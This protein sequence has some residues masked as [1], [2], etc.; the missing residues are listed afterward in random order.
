MLNSEKVQSILDK[1]GGQFLLSNSADDLATGTTE[2]FYRLYFIEKSPEL[3]GGIVEEAKADLGSIGGGS[4]GQPVVSLTMNSE[5]SRTWSRVT[6]SNIGERI[7]IVL[8][9]KVHMAPSIREKIPGGRTQIEG[10]SDINEEKDIAI[11]L[12]AGA[13][14]AP[15]NI[16]EERLVGPSLG[17]DSIS[18]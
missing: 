3:T 5:G 1:S 14:P 2:E 13:L 17:A 15:V 18:Q 12:R 6:G 4:A 8:D 11:I 10:F 16:I 7:A 9:S